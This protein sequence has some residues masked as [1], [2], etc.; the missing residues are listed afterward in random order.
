MAKAQPS[1]TPKSKPITATLSTPQSMP[2][3]TQPT[4]TISR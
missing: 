1:A 2:A 3:S 4:P